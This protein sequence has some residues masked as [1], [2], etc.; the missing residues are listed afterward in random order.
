MAK[1]IKYPKCQSVRLL[2]D[3]TTENLVEKKFDDLD[4]QSQDYIRSLVDLIYAKFCQELS[5]QK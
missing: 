4:K 3:T 2:T 5:N 1:K